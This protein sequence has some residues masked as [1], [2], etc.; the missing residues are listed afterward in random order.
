LAASLEEAEINQ[1]SDFIG[2]SYGGLILLDFALHNPSLIKTLT[3][4]EPP[5]FW[6]IKAHGI[7]NENAEKVA[8]T[9]L[10]F[11]NDISEND[12]EVFLTSVGFAKPGTSIRSHPNWNNWLTF[13]YSL[14]KNKVVPE[15]MDDIEK[16]R[17][18]KPAVLLV[19]GSGSAS[20]LHAAIDLMAKDFPNVTVIEL[21]EG[22]A[23]H[24]V[25]KKRFLETFVKFK[26][27]KH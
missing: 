10:K 17:D 7:Y 5:A 9:L 1:P 4:I 19:K 26:N 25:S 14:R 3:L 8:S 20:F 6:V 15:H 16:L 21:P 2:W 13:L 23:P 22:H 11:E 24:I 27:T 12:L 18:F